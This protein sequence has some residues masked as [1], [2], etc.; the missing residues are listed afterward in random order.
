[1]AGRILHLRMISLA[2]LREHFDTIDR[3]RLKIPST[4]AI[5][6]PWT[7]GERFYDS[8]ADVY[9]LLIYVSLQRRVYVSAISDA[10]ALCHITVVIFALRSRCARQVFSS[11]RKLSDKI[12]SAIATLSSG[13]GRDEGRC[14]SYEI[15]KT[16]QREKRLYETSFAILSRVSVGRAIVFF[17]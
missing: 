6:S 7:D 9:A 1:M 11:A 8:L 5:G 12:I 16:S 4:D 17:D 14:R 2:V 10:A 15:C 13:W 3:V